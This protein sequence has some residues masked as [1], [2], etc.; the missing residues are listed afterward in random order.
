MA[1]SEASIEELPIVT[2][3][4]GRVG[5][6]MLQAARLVIA[7]LCVHEITGAMKPTSPVY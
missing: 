3:Q 7:I 4:S 5:F 1:K 2:N 6:A